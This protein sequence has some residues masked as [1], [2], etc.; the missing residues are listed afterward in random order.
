MTVSRAVQK[1]LVVVVVVVVFLFFV[2][3]LFSSF[4]PSLGSSNNAK[5][6]SRFGRQLLLVMKVGGPDKSQPREK[7]MGLSAPSKVSCRKLG[8]LNKKSCSSQKSLDT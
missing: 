8:T 1:D 5:S 7:F 3:D 2:P 6:V 4:S